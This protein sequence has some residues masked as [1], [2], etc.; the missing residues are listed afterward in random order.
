MLAFMGWPA[1]C[2]KLLQDQAKKY[3]EAHPEA[4][5]INLGCGL[6]GTFR[7][8]DNG[9][10]RGYNIDLPDVINLRNRL[11]PA[12]ER[13]ENI[14]CDLN[15]FSWMDRIDG[16]DGAVFFAAGVFALLSAETET[17]P[18]NAAEGIPLMFPAASKL[19]PAGSP[20]AFHVIGAVPVAV[21]AV[22]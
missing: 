10:C 2:S 14:A 12:G 21:R 4:T 22:L 15:D 18:S 16:S 19:S 11:L 13:E 1:L 9:L 8:V 17:S 3:L 5:I 20:A 7:W 6:D